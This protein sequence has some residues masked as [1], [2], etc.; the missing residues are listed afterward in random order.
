MKDETVSICLTV[1]NQEDVVG[2]VAS[3]ILACA[4]KN[5]K[6]IICVLDG[7][8]DN[9]EKIVRSTFDGGEIPVK[10]FT[11]PNW[12]ETRCNN[13]SFKESSCP[14]IL[15][16][17][18]DMVLQEPDFDQ[19]MLKPFRLMDN[20]LGITNRNAQDEYIQNGKLLYK[21]VAG[22]DVNSPR[23]VVYV[24]DII[25]R[26][27]IMFDHEK[28]ASMD[29]LNEEFAPIYADDYDLCFR[30]WKQKEWVVGAYRMNY[31]S[32]ESWGHTRRHNAE[33]HAFWYASAMKNEKMVMERFADIMGGFHSQDVFVGDK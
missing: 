3:S 16:L 25:V 23:D 33:A 1:H 9:S 22:A 12:W 7:C 21:N 6:E 17:Q 19:K 10:Y 26:G 11:T 29:Y 14:Y 30:A 15:T 8:T 18:D 32:P 4:S 20:L 31:M 13:L 5:V 2:F 27:P 28:L 24:R